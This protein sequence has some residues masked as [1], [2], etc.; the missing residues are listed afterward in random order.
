MALKFMAVRVGV[1]EAAAAVVND[2][3]SEPVYFAVPL[4]SSAPLMMAV[5]VVDGVRGAV[6]VRVTVL[7]DTCRRQRWRQRC[8]RGIFEHE[9]DRA[10]LDGFI[11]GCRDG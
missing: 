6:G 10:A 4:A 7:L 2:Q 5:Y 3:V 1:V 9:G 8:R 11:E